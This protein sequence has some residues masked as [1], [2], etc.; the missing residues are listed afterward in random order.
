M[1]GKAIEGFDI[2]RACRWFTELGPINEQYI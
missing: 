2:K 1:I